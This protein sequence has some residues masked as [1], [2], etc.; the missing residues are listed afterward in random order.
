MVRFPK[1]K[2]QP[3]WITNNAYFIGPKDDLNKAKISI[4]KLYNKYKKYKH[5]RK[6]TIKEIT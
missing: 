5:I 4:K 3:K 6:F 1:S 2:S